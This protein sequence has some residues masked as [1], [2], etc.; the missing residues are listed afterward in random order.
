MAVDIEKAGSRTAEAREDHPDPKTV[1]SQSSSSSTTNPS[2]D[3]EKREQGNAHG[4]STPASS[5][6]TSAVP[7]SQTTATEPAKAPSIRSRP[8]R[9]STIENGGGQHSETAEKEAIEHETERGLIRRIPF[10][11]HP[12]KNAERWHDESDVPPQWTSLFYG[13]SCVTLDYTCILVWVGKHH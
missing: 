11:R 12:V 10:Y 6:S 9:H 7:A 8:S 13:M 3:D 1:A 5:P 2:R 4:D